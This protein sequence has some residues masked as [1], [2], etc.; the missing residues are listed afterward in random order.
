MAAIVETGVCVVDLGENEFWILGAGEGQLLPGYD[1]VVSGEEL[2][3]TL[4]KWLE[5]LMTARV[6]GDVSGSSTSGEELISILV[7][8]IASG[9]VDASVLKACKITDGVSLP[10]IVAAIVAVATIG[11]VA[12][13]F[14]SLKSKENSAPVIDI[15][16]IQ[17]AERERR[18]AETL[19]RLRQKFE[20]RVAAEKKS[21]SEAPKVD[22]ISLIHL[23]GKLKVPMVAR[24]SQI[25][26]DINED[27]AIAKCTPQ[28]MVSSKRGDLVRALLVDDPSAI[29]A[30]GEG[31]MMV[32]RVI[33]VALPPAVVRESIPQNVPSKWMRAWITDKVALAGLLKSVKLDVSEKPI[34]VRASEFSEDGVTLSDPDANIGAS[35]SFD[36]GPVVAGPMEIMALRT[37]FQGTPGIVAHFDSLTI[38]GTNLQ[39]K[40][41]FVWPQ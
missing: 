1:E 32:G 6:L 36:I 13:N 16:S 38:T 34:T 4:Q 8:A 30:A 2:S 35:L 22:A 5:D 10:V 3:N 14:I 9:D 23:L 27:S 11:I 29:K 25:A 40:G 21:L 28:W 24:L 17:K 7:D 33:A 26:C 39:A 20:A 18:N 19:A 37:L 41:R 15:A 31:E 12:D